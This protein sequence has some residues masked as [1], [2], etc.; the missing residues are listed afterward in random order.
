VYDEYARASIIHVWKLD[1]IAPRHGGAPSAI[2]IESKS[3]LKDV[4]Q[5]NKTDSVTV[6]TENHKDITTESSPIREDAK[7]VEPVTDELDPPS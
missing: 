4:Q 1:T 3:Q 6:E 2:G 7:T 5:P